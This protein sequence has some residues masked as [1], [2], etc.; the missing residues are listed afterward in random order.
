MVRHHDVGCFVPGEVRV[1]I[2]DHHNGDD[3]PDH[4]SDHEGRYRRRGDTGKRVLNMRLTAM[5]G[6]AKL[7]E[8]VKKC[9]APGDRIHRAG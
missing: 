3:P 7:V 2:F 5:A 1:E 6:L 9:A 4:L 8:L